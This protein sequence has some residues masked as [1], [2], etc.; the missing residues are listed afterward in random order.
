MSNYDRETVTFLIFDLQKEKA[1][2]KNIF[3][4][5]LKHSIFNQLKVCILDIFLFGNIFLSC[6]EYAKVLIL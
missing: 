2:K 6:F 4:K 3:S 5:V 1:G